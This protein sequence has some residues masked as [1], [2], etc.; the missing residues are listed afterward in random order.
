MTWIRGKPGILKDFSDAEGQ[1][2]EFTKSP[3]FT[4][5]DFV[6]RQVGG[7]SESLGNGTKLLQD[8]WQG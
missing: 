5:K 2:L 6:T 4:K 1:L 8:G 7:P 3:E